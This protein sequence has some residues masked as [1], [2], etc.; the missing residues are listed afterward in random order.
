VVTVYTSLKGVAQADSDAEKGTLT[1][2]YN[3]KAISEA[4]LLAALKNKPKY[5][6]SKNEN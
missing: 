3:S 6:V 4:E 1:V 2:K 5:T